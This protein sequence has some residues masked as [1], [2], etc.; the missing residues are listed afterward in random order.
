M[1]RAFGHDASQPDAEW[2]N[3]LKQP[4]TG[5]SCCDVADCR[6]YDN[7]E[8]RITDGIYHVLHRG[9]WLDVPAGKIV[10]RPDNPTG[11]FVACVHDFGDTAL[12]LCAV[13]GTG[14]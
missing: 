3:S 9:E 6:A 11:H 1:M 4:Q 8:I 7:S 10:E 13:K 12:V 14:T 2:F 5:I